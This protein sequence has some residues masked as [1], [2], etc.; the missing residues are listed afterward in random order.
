MAPKP[1][2]TDARST[3]RD[4]LR[5]MPCKKEE[6]ERSEGRA[7][8]SGNRRRWRLKRYADKF[9]P[10]LLHGASADV[11][12]PDFSQ[13]RRPRCAARNDY[14]FRSD[15]QQAAGLHDCTKNKTVDSRASF[16]SARNDKH[17]FVILR[18]NRRFRREDR[19]LFWQAAG[20]HGRTAKR[21]EKVAA[22]ARAPGAIVRNDGQQASAESACGLCRAATVEALLL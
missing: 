5:A 18:R 1:S 17:S 22:T 8:N 2:A 20:L 7:K 11:S 3:S 4:R 9:A 15:F 6:T 19:P 12:L 13:C 14:Y 10:A 16:H 21:A